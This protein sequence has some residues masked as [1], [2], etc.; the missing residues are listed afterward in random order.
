M[1]GGQFN[2]QHRSGDGFNKN[3]TNT[4][5]LSIPHMIKNRI[6]PAYLV[7]PEATVPVPKVR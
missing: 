2:S 5:I 1:F 6:D 4:N 3:N 7:E